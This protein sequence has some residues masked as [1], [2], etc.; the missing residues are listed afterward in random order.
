MSFVKLNVGG[1]RIVTTKETLTK[2]PGS[3][4]A[5]IRM[6]PAELTDEEEL[7]TY[8]DIDPLYFRAVLNWLRCVWMW[9]R[10]VRM[11]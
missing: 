2:F 4:L 6:A 1:E 11:Y 10:I 3:K 5:K 8:L 9:R 7:P